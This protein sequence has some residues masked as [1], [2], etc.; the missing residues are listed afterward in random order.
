MTDVQLQYVELSCNGEILWCLTAAVCFAGDHHVLT[1]F[2]S[3]RTLR[4]LVLSSADGSAVPFVEKLW[5][6]VFN[7]RCKQ[8]LG[9]ADVVLSMSV[10]T[11]L[12]AHTVCCQLLVFQVLQCVVHAGSHAEKVLSAL[13]ECGSETVKEAARQQLQVRLCYEWHRKHSLSCAGKR[14]AR[15]ER[16]TICVV[17]LLPAFGHWSGHCRRVC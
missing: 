1:E 6:R 9:K 17:V 3:S 7:D 5:A 13:L 2:Y 15:L 10:S 16:Q 11:G 14:D 4:H 8:Y 12:P